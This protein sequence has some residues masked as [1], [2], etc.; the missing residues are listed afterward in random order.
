MIETVRVTDEDARQ[1]VLMVGEVVA[2]M[3]GRIDAMQ[4]E[5]ERLRA[6]IEWVQ[7]VMV[8]EVDDGK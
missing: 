1:G 3:Q 5:M 7:R 4:A 2:A 6:A 8:D